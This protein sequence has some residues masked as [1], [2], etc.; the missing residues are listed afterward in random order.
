MPQLGTTTVEGKITVWL[1]QEGDRVVKGEPLFEIETDKANMEVESLGTGI[2]RK[3]LVRAGDLAKVT[4]PVA[5]IA[6]GDEDVTGLL[7]SQVGT[8]CL[9]SGAPI[10]EE[11]E[12]GNGA[13]PARRRISPLARKIASQAGLVP[14]VLN[15]LTGVG[16]RER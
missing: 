9:G 13:V 14:E 10:H 16:S 12:S 2:L 7:P 8:E 1:K 5:I 3:I 11:K 15:G 4:E 6:E